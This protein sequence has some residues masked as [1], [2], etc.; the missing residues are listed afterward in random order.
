MT[1]HTPRLSD[2]RGQAL[3]PTRAGSRMQPTGSNV[4]PPPSDEATESLRR[5]A[6][7]LIV[8]AMEAYSLQRK[9]EPSIAASAAV[10]STPADPPVA[11]YNRRRKRWGRAA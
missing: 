6:R 4:A 7:A 11:I 3:D 9:A 1:A 5:L 8:S 10:E 2:G